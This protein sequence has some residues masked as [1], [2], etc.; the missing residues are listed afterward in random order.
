MTGL[1]NYERYPYPTIREKEAVNLMN[2][3]VV[4]VLQMAIK[5]HIFNNLS[6]LELN[7]YE[8]MSDKDDRI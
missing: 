5:E 2:Q 3:L 1:G 4:I 6:L 8:I 7:D